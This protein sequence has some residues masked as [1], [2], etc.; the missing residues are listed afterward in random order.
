[1]N[2]D[3]KLDA[4]GGRLGGGDGGFVIELVDDFIEDFVAGLVTIDFD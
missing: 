2:F 1:M 4:C 3:F